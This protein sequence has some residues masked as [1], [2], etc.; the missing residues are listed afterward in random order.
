[1]HIDDE[2]FESHSVWLRTHGRHGNRL[3][4]HGDLTGADLQDI[5]LDGAKLWNVVFKPSLLPPAAS[6]AEAE[7]LRALRWHSSELESLDTPPVS[8]TPTLVV[9]WRHLVLPKK[10][11]IASAGVDASE[12]HGGDSGIR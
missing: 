7:G 10:E 11:A 2:L 12:W 9:I 6:I 8:E 3:V 1:M 5:E 4:L